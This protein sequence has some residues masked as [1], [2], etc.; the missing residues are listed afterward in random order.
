MMSFIYRENHN[1]KHF[2]NEDVYVNMLNSC[3][4]IPVFHELN[5]LNMNLNQIEIFED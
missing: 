1:I 3:Y 4:Q 5:F 2:V